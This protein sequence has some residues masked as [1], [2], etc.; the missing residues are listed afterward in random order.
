M[1]TA[2]SVPSSRV[3]SNTASASVLTMPNRLTM[4][5]SPSSAQRSPTKLSIQ[6]RLSFSY[7]ALV[8]SFAPG[9]GAMTRSRSL[10]VA[11]AAPVA[12]FTKTSRSSRVV[13]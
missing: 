4:T 6:L 3:R 2:R 1:P 10:R 8:R 5:D 12:T 11:A 13:S 9:Y 7:S